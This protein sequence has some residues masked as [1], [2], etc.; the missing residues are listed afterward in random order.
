MAEH[1]TEKQDGVL[2]KDISVFQFRQSMYELLH[3]LFA[4]PLLKKDYLEIQQ[5]GNLEPIRSFGEGGELLYKF[6]TN[7]NVN[8]LKDEQQEFYRLFVG[9]GTLLA[10]P[11]ESVYRGTDK[12]LHDYP[13][14]EM[15]QLYDRFGLELIKENIEAEDHLALELEFII[16]LIEKG[17]TDNKFISLFTEGQRLLVLHHFSK[18]IPDFSR[19]VVKH[20][21]SD[22]YKG[23][24][25]LL[26]EFIRFDSQY[27]QELD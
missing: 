14:L 5:Q 21:E 24:A 18:W 26:D 20:T 9:P 23:S 3:L 8:N 27:L 4:Q 13:S 6:F 10:P 11:W 17:L 7:N 1:M 16:Y 15:S 19:D 25:L 2:D 12:I 22:L